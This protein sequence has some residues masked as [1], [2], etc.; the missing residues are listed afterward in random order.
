M[1]CMVVIA[2]NSGGING[3][4]TCYDNKKVQVPVHDD[5]LFLAYLVL[6]GAK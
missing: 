6:F 1:L 2:F 3:I 5:C 4:G